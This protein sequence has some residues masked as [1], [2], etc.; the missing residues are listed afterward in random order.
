MP[1]FCLL[2][3][4]A[5]SVL[6]TRWKRCVALAL[7]GLSVVIHL[8]GIFGYS[9]YEAWQK[10]HE[11]PDQGRCLFDIEDTQIAAHAQALINKLTGAGNRKP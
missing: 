3:A 5:Y 4:I 9:G 8:V 11:L 6:R 2:F 1:V 7:V 10:R